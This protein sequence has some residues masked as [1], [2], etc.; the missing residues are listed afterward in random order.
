M[1]KLNWLSVNFEMGLD[2]GVFYPEGGSGV[3]WDGLLS[4]EETVVDG[5]EQTIVIDGIKT[6]QRHA[7]GE[8][9]GIIEA[10]TYPDTFYTNAL[11]Q[12]RPQYFGMSYRVQNASSYSI[13]LIY[14][15]KIPRG[16][17]SYNQSEIDPF[18]WAFTTMPVVMPE[19][20]LSA[21]MIVEVST[22]YSWT[23]AAL[24]DLLY[25]TPAADARLPSPQEVFQVF[26]DN[27]ILQIIDHG[28]G[29]WTATGPDEVVKMVDP[30][31]FEINWPSAVYISATEYTVHSL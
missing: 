30:T 6:Y 31:M 5:D 4:V 15:A 1:A 18:R 10:F 16:E 7:S 3:P 20:K 14:N 22:A 21:H 29:T 11:N 24:E 28:D 19:A 17:I 26:E 2:R 12:E 8:F 25:G 27:S 13:H 9:A 23:V